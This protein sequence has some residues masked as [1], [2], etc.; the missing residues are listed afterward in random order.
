M[1]GPDDEDDT[2][3]GSSAEGDTETEGTCD[4]RVSLATMGVTEA[5]STEEV[6]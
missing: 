2:G 5:G 1:S 4:T 6:D 3:S